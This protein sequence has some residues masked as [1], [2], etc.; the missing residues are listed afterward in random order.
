MIVGVIGQKWFGAEALKLLA[1][2][3]TVRFAIAPSQSDRLSLTAEA[4][5]VQRVHLDEVRLSQLHLDYDVD[6]LVAAHAHVF[7]PA[8]LRASA[9]WSIGY[10]PSLLPLFPG[11][12]AIEETLATGQRIAGGTIYH[13]ND[14]M[15]AG[16]IA[17]QEWCHVREGDT[18]A[19]LWR[20]ELAPMGLALILRSVEHLAATGRLPGRPQQPVSA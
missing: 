12:K 14:Q 16:D 15:D 2:V 7:V 13:L 11:M 6:L 20:R 9:A 10:H 1:G 8:S 19:E 18:P 5:G 3:A 17:F 4:F